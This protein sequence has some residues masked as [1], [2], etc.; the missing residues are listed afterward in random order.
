MSIPSAL[1]DRRL[2]LQLTLLVLLLRPQGEGLL[3]AAI[4]LVAAGGLVIP[5]LTVSA[6]T[7]MLLAAL[8]AAR[9]AAD[10]PLADNH[11]YLLAYWCFGVGLALWYEPSGS[12][13]ADDD[14][15][16]S[17]HQ[18]FE[19]LRSTSRLLVGSA[20]LCAVVWKAVL[21]P[22][23]LDG[24]FFRVTLSTDDR[25]A[26]V[27]MA[28]GLSPVQLQANRAALE[29]LPAGLE[30]LDGPVLVE[31]PRFRQVAAALTW[32]GLA[33]EALVALAF[34]LPVSARW[35]SLRHILLLAFCVATYAFAPVAGFG[36]LLIVLGLAHCDPD[37]T[38]L[39]LAYVAVFALVLCY[40]ETGMIDRL[41]G[42]F[43]A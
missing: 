20:F 10:W 41:L 34:L 17:Y 11:I 16:G 19:I 31:P 38:R 43:A 15:E 25:L 42:A 4:L 12:S 3:A 24:R 1:L 7:W 2:P 27:A 40:A 29:P 13:D 37:Q 28:A 32:G 26:P 33:L 8:M 18:P 39:R 30:V 6:R 9:I 5:T 21:A 35:P 36:W 22:D 23:Y 14:P